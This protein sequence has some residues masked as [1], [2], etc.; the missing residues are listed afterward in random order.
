MVCW[1]TISTVAGVCRIGRPSR[2]ALVATALRLSGVRTT[3]F[4]ALAGPGAGVA[5][6]LGLR[7]A[8]RLRTCG[9][10]VSEFPGFASLGLGAVMTTGPMGLFSSCVAVWAMLGMA[11]EDS[12][13]T[14]LSG[15]AFERNQRG[16]AQVDA[17]ERARVKI[18]ARHPSF[19]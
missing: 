5:V 2:L 11:A 13:A 18:G 14:K 8:A 15:V 17:S 3:S 1:S 6:D 9:R 19:S 10:T 7:P 16:R 4:A 12:N